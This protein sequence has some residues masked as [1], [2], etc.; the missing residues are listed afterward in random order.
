MTDTPREPPSPQGMPPT[1]EP[2]WQAFLERAADP[3][4][5]LNRRRVLLFVNAAFERL[6]GFAL[7]QLRGVRCVRRR[8]PPPAS[9]EALLTALVPPP[10]ARRG[11][12][13]RVRRAIPRT[14]G[15]PDWW[16]VTYLPFAGP[17]G[18]LGLLGRIVSAPRPA[19]P[20]SAPL[21]P[22]LV[23][24]REQAAHWYALDRLPADLPAQRRLMEQLRLAAR[25]DGPVLLVGE[26]GTGKHWLARVVHQHGRAAARTFALVDCARLPEAALASVLFGDPGLCWRAQVGTIYLREPARLPRELQARLCQFLATP[27]PTGRRPRLLAGC[28]IPPLGAV[29]T[30]GLLEE[31]YC[32]LS[33]F[34]I[35]L[36]PL[37]DRPD[38]LPW[39]VRQMLARLNGGASAPGA[40]LSPEAWDIVRRYTWPGNLRELY[41]V[42]AGTRAQ[43]RGE[44]IEAGDLPFYLRHPAPPPDRLLPLKSLLE[45]V[46][47][48]LIELALRQTGSNLTRAAEVLAI[49]RPQL[50]QRMKAL[51]IEG[52]KKDAEA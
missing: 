12:P 23:A 4:F 9:V 34:A 19:A 38:D 24:L 37:R 8:D 52:K 13:A 16:D 42:L 40:A 20:G 15:P 18:R 39:L 45:R 17:H 2:R 22:K 30:G 47:R 14:A 10:E 7:G 41:K 11:Q 1:A 49:W 51:G 26:A 28:S 29:R 25:L 46:E 21:P 50:Y 32:A 35:L 48:R 3:L 27:A 6:T 33:P 44:Q 43:T 31:L 5:L 36:A